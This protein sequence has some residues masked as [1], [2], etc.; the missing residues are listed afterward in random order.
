MK[1][2]YFKELKYHIM[3]LVI[4]LFFI[5]KF[6]SA[7]PIFDVLDVILQRPVENTLMYEIIRIAENISLAYIAALIFY[8]LVD[9]IPLIRAQNTTLHIL[10]R[11]LC[12]LYLYMDKINSYFKYATGISNFNTAT[13]K[14]RKAVD[15]FCF[16]S[17]TE[18]LMIKSI[19][20]GKDDGKHV[21]RFEAKKL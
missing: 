7:P 13:N 8:L 5:S 19:R 3:L 6:S 2:N 4:S 9:Y 16:G 15:D 17:S 1:R 12:S 10:E 14:E 18:F 20:N 21:E 11:E